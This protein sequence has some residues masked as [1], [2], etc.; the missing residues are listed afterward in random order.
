MLVDET[1]FHGNLQMIRAFPCLDQFKTTKTFLRW[2]RT[3]ALITLYPRTLSSFYAEPNSLAYDL[4]P[5]LLPNL[6]L[7]RTR[8]PAGSPTGAYSTEPD[9]AEAQVRALLLLSARCPRFAFPCSNA[10]CSVMELNFVAQTLVW[11]ELRASY[12][13]FLLL[14]WVGE[15]FGVFWYN[16]EA[17][18]ARGRGI[19]SYVLWSFWQTI[20]SVPEFE[21]EF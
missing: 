19:L 8:A 11:H 14:F 13:V 3:P 15:E 18:W 5:N 7:W 1:L 2:D 4:Q 12:G 20:L 21:V 6:W 10:C 17:I 9:C 16:F